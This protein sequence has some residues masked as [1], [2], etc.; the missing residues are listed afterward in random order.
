[1][2]EQSPKKTLMCPSAEPEMEGSLVF[3]IVAGTATEPRMVHFDRAKPVP[4]E[5]LTI[6]A[7]I[8][9]TEVFRIAA[10]CIETGC[11]H[12]DGKDC[13]LTSRIIEGLPTVTESL[14]ACPIRSTCRWW[15]QEGKAACLRCQQVVRD[16]YHASAELYDAVN[17]A[18]YHQEL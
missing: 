13:R 4:P 18:V 14:P 3:G 17:V 6:D 7:P 11:E 16:N 2:S 5:F 1:M 12:F 8:R 9:P 15:H 10:T